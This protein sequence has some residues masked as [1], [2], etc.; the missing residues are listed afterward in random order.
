MHV[1]IPFLERPKLLLHVEG[2][3]MKTLVIITD[4]GA[5]YATDTCMFVPQREVG[6]MIGKERRLDEDIL[7]RPF[8]TTSYFAGRVC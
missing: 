3:K 2:I 6:E 1:L 7:F 8:L 5:L 4:M